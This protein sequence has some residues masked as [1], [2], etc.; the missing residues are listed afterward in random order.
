MELKF[1][2]HI[3]GEEEGEADGSTLGVWLGLKV[4]VF[5]GSPLGAW[6]NDGTREGWILGEGGMHL[7]P[8]EGLTKRHSYEGL[9]QQDP[10]DEVL[11]VSPSPAQG[12]GLGRLLG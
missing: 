12:N 7:S 3:V 5:D 1:F 11:Q 9:R 2:Q 6:L 4:G 10:N 8:T